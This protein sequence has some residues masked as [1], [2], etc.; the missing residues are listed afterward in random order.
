MKHDG[1]K[2]NMDCTAMSFINGSAKSISSGKSEDFITRV[3]MILPFNPQEIESKQYEVEYKN[4]KIEIFIRIAGSKELDPIFNEIKN[5]KIGTPNQSGLPELLPLEVFT[6][7]RGVYPAVLASV[8]FPYRIATWVDDNHP[9]GIKMDYDY[10]AMQVT[11]GPDNNEKIQALLI[12]NRLIDSLETKSI[13][14]LQYDD[15]TVFTE[16]YFKKG[17]NTPVLHKVSA[18]TSK[19]AYKNAVQEYYLKDFDNHEIK[20]TVQRIHEIFSLTEIRTEKDLYDIAAKTIEDVLKHHIDTRRWIEPFWDGERKIHIKGQE[21]I[22]PQSP[23]NEMK[24]QPTLHVMLDMALTPIGIHVIRESNEG[25]GLLDFKFLYT[26][27][28]KIPLAVGVEFK[29]AH[30]QE[31]KKGITRQLPAYLKSIRSKHGI[32]V[33]MWFKD[34]K[35]FREPQKRDKEQMSIWLTD[36]A[37]I[38]SAEL[39]LTISSCLIDASIR[40]SASNL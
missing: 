8:I 23:K 19:T 9:T 28:D 7:N 36:E 31:I 3:D 33:V 22:V 30:H 13:K 12:I 24:I 18:L 20:D 27:N 39:D 17:I 15:I 5:F 38:I 26:T 10:E 34:S 1:I 35:Y 6:D 21:I 32:Y 37:K 29:V 14:K 40:P 4:N 25:V 11:G 2:L 16:T